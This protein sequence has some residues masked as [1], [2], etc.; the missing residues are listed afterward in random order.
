LKDEKSG[1]HVTVPKL[2]ITRNCVNLIHAISTA[3]FKKAK[4]GALKEDYE[5]TVEGYEG[6]LDALRYLMVY[7][8]HDT[9]QHITVIQGV[10]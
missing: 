2:F 1:E 10:Q 5:E 4:G 8:F 3:V 9:G 6:L 7:L